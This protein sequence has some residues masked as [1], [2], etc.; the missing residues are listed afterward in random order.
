MSSIV[1]VPAIERVEKCADVIETGRLRE[2][3]AGAVI[4]I[5]FHAGAVRL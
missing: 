3:K 4:H 1:S 5:V 2:E